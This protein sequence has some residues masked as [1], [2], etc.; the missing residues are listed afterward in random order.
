MI[1]YLSTENTLVN[2]DLTTNILLHSVKNYRYTYIF[3]EEL[4][5]PNAT[6][7]LSTPNLVIEMEKFSSTKVRI[8][9]FQ[10]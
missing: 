1:Q 10:T 9:N 5:H 4:W 6:V 8:E 7:V 3:Y 2:L